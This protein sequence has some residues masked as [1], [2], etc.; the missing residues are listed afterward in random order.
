MHTHINALGRLQVF[1]RQ[2]FAGNGKRIE[3]VSGRE[4]DGK[5]FKRIP[6]VIVHNGV[7]K[8]D[9]IGG[10]WQ[11]LIVEFHNCFLPYRFYHRHIYLRWCD[12]HFFGRFFNFYILVKFNLNNSPVYI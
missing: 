2:H 5:I 8:I 6:F 3:M 9:G 7:G 10:V 11:K 1:G 12:N 4:R